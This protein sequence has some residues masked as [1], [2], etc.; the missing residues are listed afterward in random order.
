MWNLCNILDLNLPWMTKYDRSRSDL[1]NGSRETKYPLLLHYTHLSFPTA[2]KLSSM[3]PLP[4]PYHDGSRLNMSFRIG[5]RS[6]LH[7]GPS[8]MDRSLLQCYLSTNTDG[9]QMIMRHLPVLIAFYD[10]ESTTSLGSL[11]Q[12]SVTLRVRVFSLNNY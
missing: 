6:W 7:S 1:Y 5:A 12:F 4:N 8:G 9:E 3:F 10:C 11:F 2:L